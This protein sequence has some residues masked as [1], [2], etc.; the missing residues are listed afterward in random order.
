MGPPVQRMVL[1]T[2]DLAFLHQLTIK[3]LTLS[4]ASLI[5]AIPQLKVP[6]QMTLGCAKLTVN[7]DTAP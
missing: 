6:S 4:Q 3:T 1:P 5:Q 7:Y 2:V